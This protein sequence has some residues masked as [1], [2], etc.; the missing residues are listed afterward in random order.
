[1]KFNEVYINTVLQ[2][3]VTACDAIAEKKH[4]KIFSGPQ[5]SFA[6]LERKNFVQCLEQITHSLGE[7]H[8]F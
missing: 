1:M 6:P 7:Q 4:W 5:I 8:L 3:K 2:F